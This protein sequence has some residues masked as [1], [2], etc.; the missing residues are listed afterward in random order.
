MA[1]IPWIMITKKIMQRVGRFIGCEL[2]CIWD[3]R[4]RVRGRNRERSSCEDAREEHSSREKNTWSFHG[5]IYYFHFHLFS[6]GFPVHVLCPFYLWS[7]PDFS[8]SC[9]RVF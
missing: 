5:F 1:E 3:T 7:V 9:I 8:T 4:G 6:C 2:L